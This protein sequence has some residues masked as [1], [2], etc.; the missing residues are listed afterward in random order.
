MA[1]KRLIYFTAAGLWVYRRAGAALASEGQFSVD[2]AG[3][4]SFRSFL[5][6]H[7]GALFYVVAD[8]PGE[9]FHEDQIPFLRGAERRVV[10]E[11]RLAQRYRDTRLA[12]AISLRLSVEVNAPLAAGFDAA[13]TA[14][15]KVAVAAQ[16]IA[17]LNVEVAALLK[18]GL[19]P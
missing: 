7:R 19:S 14:E 11:R 17:K 10:I 3:I 18:C 8:L 9:D 16:L 12:A 5:T 6:Q 1:T 4:A 2:E 13:L 15:L